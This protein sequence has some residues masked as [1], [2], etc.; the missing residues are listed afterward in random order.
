MDIDTNIIA[1]LITGFATLVT[2]IIILF[3]LFEM[4]KQR[5]MTYK[6]ILVV[7]KVNFFYLKEHTI[8]C[9]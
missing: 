9:D 5:K 7:P 6:P 2:A 4:Q 8:D 1:N 3:T